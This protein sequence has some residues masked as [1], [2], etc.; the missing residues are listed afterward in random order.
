MRI[1]IRVA[2]KEIAVIDANTFSQASGY[3]PLDQNYGVNQQI[4]YTL[5]SPVGSAAAIA[6]NT[7]EITFRYEAVP[8]VSP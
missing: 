1:H 8:D 5:D 4:E 2:G 7:D 3:L 6:A